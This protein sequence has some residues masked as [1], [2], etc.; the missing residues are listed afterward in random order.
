M[1]RCLNRADAVVAIRQGDGNVST[2]LPFTR[3]TAAIVLTS[4]LAAVNTAYADSAKEQELEARIA[5]LERLVE[6]LR[7][8]RG[9]GDPAVAPATATTTPGATGPAIQAASIASNA[10]A[11][12][13][14]LFTR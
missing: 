3:R 1:V 11:T 13:R 6:E 9:S 12:T 10:L 5:E 2:A 8:A 4:A 7:A 14:V